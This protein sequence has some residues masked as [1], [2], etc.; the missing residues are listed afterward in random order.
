MK[1][2]LKSEFRKLFSVRSTYV[3]LAF[4]MALEILFAFYIVG[5]H[6]P[7]T[8]LGSPTYLS[9]QATSAISTLGLFLALV[10]ILLIT[11]EY[12]YNTIV[13]TLTASKSRAR[14]LFAKFL[15]VS[16]FAIIASLVF[17]WLSL[18]LSDLA[19]HMRHLPLGV[20]TVSVWNLTW[21]LAF[22][23][24][25]FV[26]LSFF[27][28]AIIRIQVGAIAAMFLIPSTVEGLLSLLLKGNQVYLPYSSLNEVLNSEAFSKQITYTR[29]AAVALGYIILSG[30]IALLLFIRRDAN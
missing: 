8:S 15:A 27:L 10:A 17:G 24:W 12:R 19:I 11:H 4:C 14:V 2:A 9:S 30:A 29:A 3:V 28:A 1:N 20:Q 5:W 7:A 26:T 6:T 25:G 18:F 21:R 22:A 23:G 13:Y 16:V